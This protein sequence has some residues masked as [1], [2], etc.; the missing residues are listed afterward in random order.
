MLDRFEVQTA[1]KVELLQAL[2]WCV[3]VLWRLCESCFQNVHKELETEHGTTG[4]PTVTTPSAL[5][6]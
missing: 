6:V 2:Q 4:Q 5:W 3:E 1:Y